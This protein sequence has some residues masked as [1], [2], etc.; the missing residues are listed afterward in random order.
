MGERTDV[1]N[2]LRW[3]DPFGEAGF[4]LAA[5]DMRYLEFLSREPGGMQDHETRAIGYEIGL[6]RRNC[7]EHERAVTRPSDASLVLKPLTG[8]P[9]RRAILNGEAFGFFLHRQGVDPRSV[10]AP[11]LIANEKSYAAKRL[12]AVERD[13][14]QLAIF[15]LR[16]ERTGGEFSARRVDFFRSAELDCTRRL[17]SRFCV[18]HRGHLC[19]AFPVPG[20]NKTARRRLMST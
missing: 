15:Q 9:A 2:W 10:C 5:V 20:S 3:T 12:D 19:K 4:L 14:T 17:N 1:E 18:L 8:V 7:V 11:V 6:W 16:R 13:I